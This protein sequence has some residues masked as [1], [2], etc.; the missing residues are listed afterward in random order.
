MM[1]CSI[2]IWKDIPGYEG[3]YQ[4]SSLGRI[5]GPRG[6]KTPCLHRLRGYYFVSIGHNKTRDV[7]AL[8]AAAFLGPR[9]QG[10]EI[11]HLNGNKTD[12]NVA[13]L[14]YGTHDQNEHDKIEY[15]GKIKKLTEKD[16]RAIR[17]MYKNGVQRKMIADMYG[18]SLTNVWYVGTGRTFAWLQ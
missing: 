8:V 16:I 11:R 14:A 9:P 1:V 15:G 4:A 2:E 12:N 6:I 3:K 10:H 5:R 17:E 7:H 18:I 13:N